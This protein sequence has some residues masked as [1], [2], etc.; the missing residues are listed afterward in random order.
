MAKSAHTALAENP[1]SVP[2][3]HVRELI[4]TCDSSS[5]GSD[6]L[7]QPLQALAHTCADSD[8]HKGKPFFNLSRTK[9]DK[10]NF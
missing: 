5:R 1:S 7:S 3:P 4:T 9:A 2:G 10:E 6:A 8:I